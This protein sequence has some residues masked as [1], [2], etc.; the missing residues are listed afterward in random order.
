MDAGHKRKSTFIW[1]ILVLM[2]VCAAASLAVL[3]SR[4][5]KFSADTFQNTIS[6]TSSSKGTDL[7]VYRKSSPEDTGVQNETAANSGDGNLSAQKVSGGDPSFVV[8]DENTVWQTETDVE[9]FSISYKND[10]GD[11]TI[12]TGN[13]DKLFAPG[14]SNEYTFTLE[15][16]GDV[17]LDYSMT[18]EA[19]V[20]GTDLYLPINARVWDY[21]NKYLL[22]SPSRSADVLELNNVNESGVLGAGRYAYYTLEWEWLFE[23]DNNEY[24]TMIGDLAVDEDLTLTVKIMT[25]ARYDAEPDKPEIIGSG[26]ESP[27]TGDDMPVVPLTVGFFT[28]AVIGAASCFVKRKHDED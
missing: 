1:V 8:Y 25:T 13:G 6:L 2:T 22:G 15:N 11:I 20:D 17:P 23:N 16:N 19:W 14:T 21:T 26:I 27:K 5:N 18:M 3:F 28:A 9:I 24:D 7:T 10:R 4:M 12:N